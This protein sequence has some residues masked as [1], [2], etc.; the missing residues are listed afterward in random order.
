MAPTQQK[1]ELTN[2]SAAVSPQKVAKPHP[3]CCDNLPT[4]ARVEAAGGGTAQH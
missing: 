4:Y 2:D 1:V 3:I